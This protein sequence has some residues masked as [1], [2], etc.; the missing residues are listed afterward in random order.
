MRSP[1]LRRRKAAGRG[2]P[3]QCE[4][5][6]GSVARMLAAASDGASSRGGLVQLHLA[7]CAQLPRG[8]VRVW[9]ENL[10]VSQ[11]HSD[12][13]QAGRAGRQ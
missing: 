3:R 13:G 2:T 11:V 1:R 10:A 7:Q 9:R 8:V 6:C 4:S 5:V 12:K